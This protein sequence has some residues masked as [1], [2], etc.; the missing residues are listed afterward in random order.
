ME[1]L[2]IVAMFLIVLSHAAYFGISSENVSQFS[3]SS[4]IVNWF[5]LGNIGNHI[6]ILISGYYLYEKEFHFSSIKKLCVQVWFYSILFLVIGIGIGYKCS[7]KQVINSLFP[8]ITEEYW[9]VSTYI[10][11]ILISPIL[12][13]FIKNTSQEMLKNMISVMLTLWFIIPTFL[14][15][16]FNLNGNR[17]CT[18]MCLYFCGAYMHKYP[19]N[20]FSNKELRK[21][22]IIVSIILLYSSTIVIGW[23]EKYVSLAVGNGGVLFNMNS[24]LVLGIS[25]GLFAIAVYHVPFY[26]KCI[27]II[28]GATFGIYLIHEHP[29]LRELIWNNWLNCDYYVGSLILPIQILKA[30]VI[31]YGISLLIEI[32]RK[33]FI[34]KYMLNILDF[35]LSRYNKI[36]NRVNKKVLSGLK[37]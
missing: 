28:G 21:T 23:L 1:L 33:R 4:V 35:L 12:N 24:I 2:R 10:V 20:I 30:V 15:F 6:F 19:Q 13:I 18:F 8:I 31:V 25:I 27:N 7:L 32:L 16:R 14:L 29:I 11:M 34:E 9:F 22:T 17:L 26:N 36:I 5:T 37:I 3:F